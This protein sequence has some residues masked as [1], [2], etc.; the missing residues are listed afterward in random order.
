MEHPFGQRLTEADEVALLRPRCDACGEDT[1]P[2]FRVA[3]RVPGMP[4]GSEVC[5]GC[6]PAVG[7]TGWSHA[8]GGWPDPLGADEPIPE[9]GNVPAGY[10]IIGAALEG[11]L[12]Q[13]AA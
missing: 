12:W 11:R 6:F 4:L 3:V 8:S 5:A 7:L 2:L 13:G 9:E 10:Q 1:N